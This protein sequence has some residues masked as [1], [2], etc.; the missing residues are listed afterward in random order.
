MGYEEFWAR[1]MKSAEQRMAIL[2]EDNETMKKLKEEMKDV[3]NMS[4][5]AR[6]Q[7]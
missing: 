4:E 1:K 5:P 2:Q 7:I 6:V 3:T